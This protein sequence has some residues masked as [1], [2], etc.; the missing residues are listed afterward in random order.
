MKL[1]LLILKLAFF[2]N[3]FNV[4]FSKHFA[5]T[6]TSSV[7]LNNSTNHKSWLNLVLVGSPGWGVL[8]KGPPFLKDVHVF[9]IPQRWG[10]HLC[11]GQRVPRFED[12]FNEVFFSLLLSLNLS[13]CKLEPFPCS[14][15]LASKEESWKGREGRKGGKLCLHKKQVYTVSRL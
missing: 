4:K 11:P 12:P 3:F 9:K 8:Q 1:I 14:L 10:L 13:W 7:P 5:N 15:L 6:K 2:I